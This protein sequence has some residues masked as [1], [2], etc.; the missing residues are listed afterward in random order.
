[1]EIGTY[2]Q[3][4][5]LSVRRD[6]LNTFLVNKGAYQA[7]RSFRVILI[8]SDGLASVALTMPMYLL[9]HLHHLVRAVWCNPAF[10][11]NCLAAS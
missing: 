8:I 5:D 10:C 4:Q 7:H 2:K 6:G 9:V 11:G 1:M 3:W